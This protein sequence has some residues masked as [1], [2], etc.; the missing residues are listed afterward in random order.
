MSDALER[1]AGCGIR[2]FAGMAGVG[3]ELFGNI[4]VIKLWDIVDV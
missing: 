2:G 1:L 4:I 3:V